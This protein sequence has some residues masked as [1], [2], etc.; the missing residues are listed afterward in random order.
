MTY[1]EYLGAQLLRNLT[2]DRSR[3]SEPQSCGSQQV[4]KIL[5]YV[6]DIYDLPCI[7]FFIRGQGPRHLPAKLQHSQL[8]MVLEMMN[9]APSAG[10]SLMT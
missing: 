6:L 1:S 3:S 4:M 2:G 9:T 8:P 7:V 10:R 5:D